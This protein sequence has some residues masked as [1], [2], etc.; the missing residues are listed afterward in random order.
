MNDAAGMGEAVLGAINATC[1][2]L[3]KTRKKRPIPEGL[4][5]PDQLAAWG[6]K[7]DVA[8]HQASKPGVLAIDVA[9]YDQVREEE[10]RRRRAGERK[11]ADV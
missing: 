6:V 4:P 3:S 8:P 10:R 2:A 5:R 1:E 7:D 9:N 11:Q